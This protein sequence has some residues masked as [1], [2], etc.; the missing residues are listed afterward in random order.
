MIFEAR[1]C[2]TCQKATNDHM[3]D[4][5][6]VVGDGGFKK[7]RGRDK[8]RTALTEIFIANGSDFCSWACLKQK[9]GYPKPPPAGK[10]TVNKKV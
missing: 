5:W 2:D 8:S 1:R 4:A 10:S 7:Y 9:T 6:I 3:L